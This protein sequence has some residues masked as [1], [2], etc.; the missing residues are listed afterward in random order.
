MSTI[1]LELNGRKYTSKELM[2]STTISSS[3]SDFEKSTLGFCYDWLIGKNEFTLSTS[4]STGTPKPITLKRK[5]MEASA[6]LTIEALKLNNFSSALI[7]LDTK[8]IAGQMMLVRSFINGMNIIATEPTANP[9]KNI[10]QSIDFT[11]LVPYQVEAILHEGNSANLD[12]LKCCIIGGA[13][14]SESLKKKLKEIKSPMFATYG[15]TET[16]SHIALQKLNGDDANE[17][18]HVLGDTK[19]SQDERGCLMIDADY[20]DDQVITNDLVTITD[21]KH[22]T[23]LGRFDNVI[24]SGGVKVSPESIE[25]KI[26]SIFDDEGIFNRCFVAG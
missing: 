3:K 19:I 14:I 10:S 13:T 15:M 18:F 11:A 21:A 2:D 25:T 26:E 24:N 20:L 16:I 12:A 1:W 4:G 6:T 9:F 8:Y 7:C 5:Q 17:N 23:W 22:F